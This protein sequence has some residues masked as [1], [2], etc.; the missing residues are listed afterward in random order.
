M[1][2]VVDGKIA[3]RLEKL[4]YIGCKCNMGDETIT[5]VL[6]GQPPIV[7]VNNDRRSLMEEICSQIKNV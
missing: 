7:L 2:I 6:D 4:L 1:F 3:F 5:I